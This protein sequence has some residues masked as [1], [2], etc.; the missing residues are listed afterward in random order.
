LPAIQFIALDREESSRLMHPVPYDPDNRSG[1]YFPNDWQGWILP[2]DWCDR[3]DC[4][5]MQNRYSR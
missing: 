3:L 5:R 4:A 1:S 2:Q